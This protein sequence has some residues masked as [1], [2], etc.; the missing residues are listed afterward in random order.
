MASRICY[1][2]QGRNST[3]PSS[4][5]GWRTSGTFMFWC[6][7]LEVRAEGFGDQGKC[8]AASSRNEWQLLTSWF[9]LF[10]A[11]DMAGQYNELGL[12]VLNTSS[13]ASEVGHASPLPILYGIF[14][15]EEIILRSSLVAPCRVKPLWGLRSRMALQEKKNGQLLCR[16]L[17]V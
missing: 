2:A 4:Y 6:Q 1:G 15:S 11:G 17:K 5:R 10:S 9:S 7:D 12:S 3:G 14:I 8:Q 16:E 13:L